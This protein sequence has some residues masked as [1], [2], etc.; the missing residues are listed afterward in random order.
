M[1]PD[2]AIYWTLVNFLKPLATLKL[3]KSPTFFAIFEKVSKSIILL[4]KSFL[5]N[6]YRHLIIF[7][8]SHCSHSQTKAQNVISLSHSFTHIPSLS[9]SSLSLVS[10][11][12]RELISLK[13]QF[14]SLFTFSSSRYRLRCSTYSLCLYLWTTLNSFSLGLSLSLWVWSIS[15]CVFIVR[16]VS[17]LLSLFV[18]FLIVC[19]YLWLYLKIFLCVSSFPSLDLTNLSSLWDTFLHLSLF[20]CISDSETRLGNLFDFGQVFNACGNN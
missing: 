19:V 16:S 5:G 18:S 17:L 20:L 15:L 10:T 4:V 11:L 13:W 2:W 8:W 12:S 6:F 1:W 3:P 9:F 14:I 7:F